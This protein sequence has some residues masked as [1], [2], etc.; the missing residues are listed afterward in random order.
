MPLR[1]LGCKRIALIGGCA[2]VVC[3]SQ[4]RAQS[5]TGQLE[6]PDGFAIEVFAQDLDAPRWMAFGPDGDLY[7]TLGRAGRVVRLSDRDGDGRAE[8][9]T[10]VLEGLNRPHGLAWHEGDLWVA[11]M[12]E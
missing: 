11:E 8:S 3:A 1:Q 12:T 10:T 6:A 7:V 2:L 5:E 4:S 9:V